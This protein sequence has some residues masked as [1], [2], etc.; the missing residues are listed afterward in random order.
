MSIRLIDI[1]KEAEAYQKL[2]EK[3][4]S[5]AFNSI[6]WL[7][8]IKNIKLYGIYNDNTEL[9]G[10]F[11]FFSFKK[12]GASLNITPPFSIVISVKLMFSYC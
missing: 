6:P 10:S 11:Y 1:N 9:I 2:N 12:W 5:S 8:M 3:L 7:K 4:K